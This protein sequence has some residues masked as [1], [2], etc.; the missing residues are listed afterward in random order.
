MWHS[1]RVIPT[2]SRHT[3]YYNARVGQVNGTRPVTGDARHV[4]GDAHHVIRCVFTEW[5]RED[6]VWRTST[7]TPVPSSGTRGS[8]AARWSPA[9]PGSRVIENKHSKRDRTCPHDSPSYRR[10]DSVLGS[11]PTPRPTYEHL[12]SPSQTTARRF[13]FLVGRFN[14]SRVLVNDPPARRSATVSL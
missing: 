11:R 3:R 5:T 7:D 13:R 4:I 14:V 12:P 2:V 8:R 6:D 9:P 1:T 10:S